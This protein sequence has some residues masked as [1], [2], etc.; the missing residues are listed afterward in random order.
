MAPTHGHTRAL[1]E[2]DRAAAGHAGHAGAADAAVGSAARTRDR[3]R[4]LQPLPGC[5]ADRPWLALPRAPPPRTPGLDRSRVEA[6]REQAAREVL[7]ADAHRE[8][9]AARRRIEVE[10]PH[11]GDR[12]RHATREV[13]RASVYVA[14][15]SSA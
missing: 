1:S 12:P 11:R 15:A 3:R 5:A 8:E 2:Q 13:L 10:S 4:H 6:V 9:A 7:P 14:P